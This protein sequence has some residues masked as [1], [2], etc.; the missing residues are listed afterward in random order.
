MQEHSLV[1]A[2]TVSLGHLS[3]IDLAASTVGTA[4]ASV[5]GYSIIQGFIRLVGDELFSIVSGVGAR[6]LILFL[7]S[8]SLDKV[9]ANAPNRRVAKIA[10][11][12]AAVVTGVVLFV[13]IAPG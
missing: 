8:S 12:Q 5:T 9:L 11:A 3:T 1:I 4:V 6:F 13:S 2:P 10:C 7:L